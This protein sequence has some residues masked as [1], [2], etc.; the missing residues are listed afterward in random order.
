MLGFLVGYLVGSADEVQVMAVQE[1]ADDI[2][3]EGEG[4]SAV[5][6]SPALYVF[7]WV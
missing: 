6:L 2:R 4:D 1:L 7:I 5:V 3:P